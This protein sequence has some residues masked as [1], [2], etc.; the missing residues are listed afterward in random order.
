MNE[1][2]AHTWSWHLLRD[3]EHNMDSKRRWSL[4]KQKPESKGG[5]E[6][7]GTP[8]SEF[9]EFQRWVVQKVRASGKLRDG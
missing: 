3:K 9:V 8:A 5:T 4:E 2:N 6:Q 7:W 1:Q